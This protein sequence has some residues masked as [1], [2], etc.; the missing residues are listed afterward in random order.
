MPTLLT[1]GSFRVVIY[2]NDHAP[3][4]VHVIGRDGRAVFNLSDGGVELREQH[5]LKK[6]DIKRI[7]N[8]LAENFEYL[9][10]GERFMATRDEYEKATA[11][12]ALRRKYTPHVIDARYDA[13]RERLVLILSTEAEISLPVRMIE[14]LA[15]ASPS[16]LSEIEIEPFGFGL[17]WPR[18]DMDTYIPNLLSGVMGSSKWMAAMLGKA[19]G[20]A[21]T[22]PK[23]AAARKNGKKGGRPRKIDQAT[24]SA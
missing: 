18:I 13:V 12:G 9:R 8:T 1:F 17:H 23:V 22:A 4:H 16:D 11:Q 20:A 21:R 10:D 15:N 5:G 19:G 14:G 2:L 7:R 3:M 24:K 6:S